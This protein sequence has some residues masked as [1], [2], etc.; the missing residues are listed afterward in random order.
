M[1]TITGN[2]YKRLDRTPTSPSY[3]NPADT[4]TPIIAT[5]SNSRNITHKINTIYKAHMIIF[6]QYNLISR[7]RTIG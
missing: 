1:I 2:Q 4:T 3:I 5:T 7:Q 6:N